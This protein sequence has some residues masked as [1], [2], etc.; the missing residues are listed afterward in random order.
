[1]DARALRTDGVLDHLD[2][3]LVPLLQEVLDLRALAVRVPVAALAL[4]ALPLAALLLA[5]LGLG[6]AFLRGPARA[7]APP[8]SSP[9]TAATALARGGPLLGGSAD[10]SFGGGLRP[11]AA[12]LGGVV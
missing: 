11:R 12:G 10:L 9:A 8:A 5:L 4:A 2:D 7:S 6:R 3:D 1:G